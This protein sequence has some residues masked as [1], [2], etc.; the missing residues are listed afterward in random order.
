M[1]PPA[2]VQEILVVGRAP[3]SQRLHAPP[4]PAADHEAA[5]QVVVLRVAASER[6]VAGEGRPDA[7]V[8][9]RINDRRDGH[10]QPL[11]AGAPAPGALRVLAIRPRAARPRRLH[12]LV[13][14]VGGL[15]HVRAGQEAMDRNSRSNTA[16]DSG[17]CPLHS[18][19]SRRPAHSGRLPP[20]SGTSPARA[21]L[22]PRRSRR[23]SSPAPPRSPAYSRRAPRSGRG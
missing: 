1:L 12:R 15:P 7:V 18:G 22:P 16:L 2:A 21:W 3:L 4:T 17:Q 23:P 6:L 13:A 14:V 5:Q 19:A 10:G 8:R 20:P 9:L 11:R